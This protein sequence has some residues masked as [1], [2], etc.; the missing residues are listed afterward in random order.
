[1]RISRESI[2]TGLNSPKIMSIMDVEFD[3]YFG[4]TEG[5]F[6]RFWNISIYCPWDVICHCSKLCKDTEALSNTSGNE[7]VKH[8]ILVIPN[9]KIRRIF[10]KQIMEYFQESIRQDGE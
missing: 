9:I 2:F 8:F 7:V 10:T 3:E 5:K 6:S 4:F 1:M